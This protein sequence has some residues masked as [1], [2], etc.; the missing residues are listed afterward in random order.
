MTKHLNYEYDYKLQY[1]VLVAD[2]THLFICSDY[3]DRLALYSQSIWTCQ[4]TGKSGLTHQEAWTS[5]A[6]VRVLL[7]A[8]FPS[9]LVKPLLQMIH[10]SKCLG[11]PL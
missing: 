9:P 1:T 5:E 2:K 3:E 11:S 4:C 10:H 6:K 7:N 8:S